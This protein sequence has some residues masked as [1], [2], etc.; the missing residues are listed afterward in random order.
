MYLDYTYWYVL[1]CKC[2]KAYIYIA[3]IVQWTL[4]AVGSRCLQFPKAAIQWWLAVLIAYTL[5]GPG[6]C[7]NEWITFSRRFCYLKCTHAERKLHLSWYAVG[8][9]NNLAPLLYWLYMNIIILHIH[10]LLTIIWNEWALFHL[11]WYCLICL[12]K[13]KGYRY[14]QTKSSDISDLSMDPLGS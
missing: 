13:C 10:E 6:H 7:E 1:L 8:M 5:D 2:I 12:C 9:T 14:M 11:F 3:K 4:C